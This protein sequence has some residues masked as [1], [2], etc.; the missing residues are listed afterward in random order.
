MTTTLYIYNGSGDPSSHDSW[1]DVPVHRACSVPAPGDYIGTIHGT[2]IWQVRQ[3]DP[4]YAGTYT[5]E[6]VLVS[7]MFPTNLGRTDVF[8]HRPGGLTILYRVIP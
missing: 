5:I 3:A 6:G 8:T 2:G 4:S 7:S 1:A